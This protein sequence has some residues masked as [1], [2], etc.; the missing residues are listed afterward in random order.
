MKGVGAGVILRLKP[1]NLDE[2]AMERN[3]FQGPEI[4]GG[5]A[6]G[7]KIEGLVKPRLSAGNGEWSGGEEHRH[8]FGA[9]GAIDV[10]PNVVVLFSTPSSSSNWALPLV[11]LLVVVWED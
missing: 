6:I 8:L 3:E 11:A 7:A 1:T 5:L 2:G 9:S 10:S 4:E